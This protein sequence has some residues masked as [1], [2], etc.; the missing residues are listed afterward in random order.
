M[1]L[2]F[3]IR[4]E[5]SRIQGLALTLTILGLS[6][7]S[8]G[9]ETAESKPPSVPAA[10]ETLEIEAF[11]GALVDKV[12]VPVPA[13]IFAV[14]DKLDEPNWAAQVRL[15][16][17]EKPETD[18]LRL[19]LIF[20]ATVGEGFIAV[21]AEETKPIQEIGRRV[22]RLAEALGLQDAVVPH[23]QS[24]IDS[25]DLQDWRKVRAEFDRTQ[26]TVRDTM[27]ELNDHELSSLVSLGGW[28][29]GTGERSL[30]SRQGGTPQ[31]TRPGRP[32]P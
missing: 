2:F 10:P 26:Q 8:Q 14:L 4:L 18:R 13:E 27:E 24:I 32:L 31:P 30:Q 19:A 22:L 3:R 1:S 29:R 20:G 28:L 7:L 11:P 25:A 9:Q 21:E 17:M 12:V 15:P 6:S 5:S 16:K 23:C